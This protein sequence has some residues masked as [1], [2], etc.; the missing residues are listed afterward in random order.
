MAYALETVIIQHNKLNT[1]VQGLYYKALPLL[2]V[3]RCITLGWQLLG[4]RY[5][6]LGMPNFVCDCFAANAYFLQHQ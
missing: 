4:E 2:G 1:L 6:G 5:Q 3:N